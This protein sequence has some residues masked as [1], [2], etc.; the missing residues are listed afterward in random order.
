MY[1]LWEFSSY[2]FNNLPI[3]CNIGMFTSL[4]LIL[5]VCGL[6][7]GLTVKGDEESDYRTQ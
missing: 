4:S 1:G 3:I 7:H 6:V 2:K 5:S